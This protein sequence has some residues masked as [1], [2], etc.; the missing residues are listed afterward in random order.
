MNYRI[1]ITPPAEKQIRRLEHAVRA[2]VVQAIQ[3]L[4]MN[5]RPP[6]SIKLKG[7]EGY[8]MRVGDYHILYGIDDVTRIV[9]IR[10]VGHRSDVYRD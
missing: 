5:P 1:I 8:R 10:R 9:D 3:M 4:V 6:N 2:S 7:R